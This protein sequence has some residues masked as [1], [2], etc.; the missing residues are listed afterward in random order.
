M[1]TFQGEIDLEWLCKQCKNGKFMEFLK[2]FPFNRWSEILKDGSTLIHAACQSNDINALV[3]IF[4]SKKCDINKTDDVHFRAI[5][6]ATLNN[7]VDMIEILLAAGSNMSFVWRHA[8][9]YGFE[10]VLEMLI[11]NGKRVQSIQA[12]GHSYDFR[13]LY[14]HVEKFQAKVIQCRDV[15][16]IL[17]GLKKRRQVLCKLDRFLIQQELATAIWATRKDKMWQRRA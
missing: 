12:L 16:V 6:Y 14:R 9:H 11:S 13:V 8:L 3:M 15:I 4:K 2:R 7:D 10:L 17:L 1:E 5:D